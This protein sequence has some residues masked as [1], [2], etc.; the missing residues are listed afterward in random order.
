MKIV[1]FLRRYWPNICSSALYSVRYQ[2][3]ASSIH[4]RLSYLLCVCASLLILY[5]CPLHYSIDFVVY[6]IN[7]H[8]LDQYT[9]G[10]AL[11]NN[12]I[13]I[14]ER[15]RHSACICDDIPK[16][17]NSICAW[18]NVICSLITSVLR[19]FFVHFVPDLVNERMC[20]WMPIYLARKANT[21]HM[22]KINKPSMKSTIY[23][24]WCNF[25]LRFSQ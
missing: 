1:T 6:I 2:L 9:T 12:S 19:F 20:M 23:W 8:R 18:M 25:R 10:C 3:S 4:I 7:W 16:N 15:E 13:C 11:S 14:I 22:H 24:A 21:T 5:L 17:V